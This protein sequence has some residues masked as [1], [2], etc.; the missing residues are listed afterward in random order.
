MSQVAE[1]RGATRRRYVDGRL[2]PR[3]RIRPGVPVTIV[4]LSATGALVESGLRCKPGARCELVL[5]KDAEQAVKARVVR[6]FVARLT[7][8]SVRY[9]T[10]MV[11]EETRPLPDE[12]SLVTGYELL[13]TGEGAVVGRVGGSRRGNF[14]PPADREA[15]K[16]SVFTRD[17]R[18]WHRP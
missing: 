6:C 7:S 5:G 4:D 14:E 12:A 3:A 10:A 17:H 1:R 2:P 16:D 9:R 8:S 18:P 15:P 13:T 11:F